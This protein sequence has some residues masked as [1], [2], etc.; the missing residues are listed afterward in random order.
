MTAS[1]E[2]RPYRPNQLI[3]PGPVML[4][5]RHYVP[6]RL[7]L[8]QAPGRPAKA[9][10]HISQN[11]GNSALPTNASSSIFARTSR[12]T[13]LR[14]TIHRLTKIL[15]ARFAYSIHPPTCPIPSLGS[16]SAS[17][18]NWRRTWPTSRWTFGLA[19]RN[20]ASGRLIIE[21]HRAL[22]ARI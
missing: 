10:A 8:E 2:S 3:A 13:S 12:T 6:R 4:R 20:A 9:T 16:S 18:L 1:L 19:T 11:I 14:R 21:P 17:S 7:L 15:T 5:Q 22:S